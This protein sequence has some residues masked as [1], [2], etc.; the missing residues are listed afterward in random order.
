MKPIAHLLDADAIIAGLSAQRVGKRI[1]VLPEVDSTNTFA[2]KL[3]ERPDVD[4]IVV[5]AERQ[6]S[7]RG[8]LGRVWHCPNGAGLMFTVL[9]REPAGATTPAA[10]MMLAGFAVVR[11][12]VDST[13]VVPSLRWPNDV[14]VGDRK[15][16]GILVES[17]REDDGVETIAIGVGVNCLQQAGHFP[18]EVRDRAVSLDMLSNAPIDRQSVA[19]SVLATLDRS[20]LELV[21]RDESRLIELWQTH[22]AD[23]GA[24]V[25]LQSDGHTY[26]G[27]IIDIHPRDGLLVQLD[28]GGR[29]QFDPAVTTRA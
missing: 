27:R 21:H 15:L 22:S 18:P 5:F 23:I 9:L 20:L 3:A 25:E 14:Y 2:L 10:W 17:R 8:R 28:D 7:G 12:I 6:T 16:A 1:V 4:G 19:C 29:R 26:R 13:D 24:R 11:G